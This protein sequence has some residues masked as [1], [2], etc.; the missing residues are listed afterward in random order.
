M[1]F[2]IL[3][4][5][6]FR[7]LRVRGKDVNVLLNLVLTKMSEYFGVLSGGAGLEVLVSHC[8]LFVFK[9]R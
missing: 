7:Q 1:I 2:D 5:A 9:G 4:S 3:A 8:F 6:D